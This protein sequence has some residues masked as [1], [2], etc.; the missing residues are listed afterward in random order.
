MTTSPIFDQSYQ[1]WEGKLTPHPFRVLA[2]LHVGTLNLFRR[3]L[4]GMIVL[5]GLVVLLTAGPT[6]FIP[7]GG[8]PLDPGEMTLTFFSVE[9]QAPIPYGSAPLAF[10]L[11]LPLVCSGLVASDVKHNALLMYFSKSL[12]R[13]D[14]VAGKLAIAT[15]A[16]G[17]FV[18]LAPLLAAMFALFTC[19]PPAG[20]LPV[21]YTIR[22]VLAC[23]C[24][25]P[26]A[27]LPTASLVLAV[28]SCT[29]RTF[30]AGLGWVAFYVIDFFVS[31][32]LWWFAKLD[33]A[34][35]LSFDGNMR[36]IAREILPDRDPALLAG[37]PTP[38]LAPPMELSAWWSVLIL[39]GLT[40]LS[41]SVVYWRISSGERR[42]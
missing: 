8:V 40:A 21:G 6:F 34:Y 31:H 13:T 20:G 22:L 25:V 5:G 28:S 1:P 17:G 36:R 38:A 32:I 29:R 2:I 18:F 23:L 14:Y 7:L 3:H 19:Q 15:V 16:L 10:L 9:S 12:W 35:L 11:L 33:W 41:L 24:L 27:L 26:L 42:A 39:A 30:L 4:T 37:P